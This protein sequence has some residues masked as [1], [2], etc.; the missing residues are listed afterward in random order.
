M[1]DN[2][3]PP[4]FIDAWLTDLRDD[5]RRGGAI[6]LVPFK[7]ITC[8]GLA[9]GASY[10]VDFEKIWGKP[11]VGL[12]FFATLVTFNGLLLVL[13]WSAFTRIYELMSEPK[14]AHFLR[15]NGMLS[16]YVFF[17]NYIHFAQILALLS[18]GVSLTAFLADI[19]N[20]HV[21]AGLFAAPLATL[22]YALW[23]AVGA[24]HLMQDLVWHRSTFDA[25]SGGFS[26]HQGGK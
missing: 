5:Y 22:I 19:A 3:R 6:K 10:F 23:Y 16:E 9:L 7:I 25:K 12:V 14:F 17:V 2:N 1:T 11:E 8:C 24:V 13:S 26:V 15:V 20:P 18:S 4:R 21:R